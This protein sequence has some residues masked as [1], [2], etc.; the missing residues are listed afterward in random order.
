MELNESYWTSR[1]INSEVGW[2]IGYPSPAI[3]KFMG[4][5]EDKSA[6]IL[7]PGCGNAY[8]AIC[9]WEN[10]F[11]NVYLLDYSLIP[12][13]QFARKHPEF[14]KTQLLNMDFFEAKGNYDFIIEQ[15]FFC[16]LKPI[17]RK[18]YAEQMLRLLKSD[19]LL[20]G[21]LFNI[22]LFDDR[23]PFG[24]NK[25]EYV[26]LFSDCFEIEKMETAYNS[27][28]ER[29]GNELFIK[30]KPKDQKSRT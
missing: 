28:P 26:Q 11:E 9:L 2:D 20:V 27:I 21:L 5:V 4:Q 17:L 15:T 30:M 16:A 29:Q 24:G 18:S 13:E 23:P 6:K 8:E 25:R 7:I 10:G 22:P 3:V 12:L 1:Y 14:P 19:G